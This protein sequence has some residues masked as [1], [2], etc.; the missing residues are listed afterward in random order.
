MFKYFNL[1]HPPSGFVEGTTN[2]IFLI[3]AIFFGITAIIL[4]LIVNGLHEKAKIEELSQ[5]MRPKTAVTVKCRSCSSLNF[6]GDLFCSKCGS[7]I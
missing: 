5:A 4:S 1:K 2:S 7:R 3:L 6:E